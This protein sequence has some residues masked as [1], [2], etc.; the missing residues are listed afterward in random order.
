MELK[1]NKKEF[2]IK[3]NKELDEWLNL[4]LQ[5]TEHGKGFYKGMK[6][7]KERFNLIVKEL[8]K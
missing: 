3:F 5:G 8:E 2:I 1:M 7:A 4:E 6:I